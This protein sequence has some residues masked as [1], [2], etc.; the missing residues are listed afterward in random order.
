V[1]VQTASLGK[2]IASRWRGALLAVF[3]SGFLRSVAVVAGGT[4]LAQLVHLASMPVVTRLYGPQA[5]GVFNLF[6]SMVVVVS[7]VATLSY[8]VAIV[9][10]RRDAVAYWLLKASVASAVAVSAISGSPTKALGSSPRICAMS[11][12]PRPSLRALPAQS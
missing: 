10:P 3:A 1:I 5:Y 11:T 9:L 4:A 7:N 6:V 12:M 2:S 8:A